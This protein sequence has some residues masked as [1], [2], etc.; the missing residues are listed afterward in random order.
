MLQFKKVAA[1]K[2]TEGKGKKKKVIESTDGG[3]D[4]KINE[5]EFVEYFSKIMKVETSHASAL[6]RAA[7]STNDGFLEYREFLGLLSILYKGTPEDK[8]KLIFQSY[9]AD[10]SGEID[11]EEMRKMLASTLTIEDP[12]E[13][14]KAIEDIIV[15]A[16]EEMDTDGNETISLEELQEAF[17]KR[18]ELMTE[19]FGQN[20]V[21]VDNLY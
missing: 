15:K 19:Y 3:G 21:E 5:Q 10:N 11:E 4:D 20:I 12:A 9:D 1:D 8:L 18:P 16:F 7:D 6:F 13:K 2:K 17:Q 14:D